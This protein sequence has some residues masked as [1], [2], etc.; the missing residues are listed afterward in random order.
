MNM[1]STLLP[2]GRTACCAKVT[3]SAHRQRG[4]T[5]MELMI[6]VAIVGILAAIAYPSYAQYVRKSK[7]STAQAALVDIANKQQA[8]QLDRRAYTATLADVAF[9]TPPEIAR[10]YT[11][12]VVVDNATSPM[13]FVAT[14][15]PINNQAAQ[16]EQRL[17]ITQ[18]GARTPAATS[19][20]WER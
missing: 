6:A 11:F 20:Y 14:A 19:G 7:R 16:S 8:Y 13:T 1:R 9:S 15:T 3:Y 5:L 4:F 12:T 18:A 17:T 2:I 10:D